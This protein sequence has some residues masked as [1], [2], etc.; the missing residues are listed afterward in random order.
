MPVA[1]AAIVPTRLGSASSSGFAAVSVSSSGF[2]AVTPASAAD[3][4]GRQGRAA[5]RA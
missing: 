3:A 1:T 5:H 2:A 4:L